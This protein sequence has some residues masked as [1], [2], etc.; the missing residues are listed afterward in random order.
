MFGPSRSLSM[1]PPTE[2]DT[3]ES[4]E[5]DEYTQT[6]LDDQSEIRAVLDVVEA[7][8][9]LL[10]QSCVPLSPPP[11]A[12]PG[13]SPSLPQPLSS[14]SISNAAG[15]SGGGGGN[16]FQVRTFGSIGLDVNVRGSDVD[17]YVGD[18]IK[19]TS[20]QTTKNAPTTR[21]LSFPAPTKR[22][23][24]FEV[25]KSGFPPHIIFL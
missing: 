15:K 16:W 5:L 3:E 14:S 19:N 22:N 2:R 18:S 23:L 6:L 21:R 4:A 11:Y 7:A 24:T 9:E 12:G 25:F 10:L 20:P 17:M 13:I 8:A 1:A